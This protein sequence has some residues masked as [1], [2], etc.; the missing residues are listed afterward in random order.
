MK[1]LNKL[2]AAGAFVL[3]SMGCVPEG[4][5]I[6][7]IRPFAGFDFRVSQ[8]ATYA[9][10]IPEY[11][12]DV[13][14]HPDDGGGK[15]GVISD[16]IKIYPL[17]DFALKT[18]LS[19][20]TKSGASLNVSGRFSIPASG[21]PKERD[22]MVNIGEDKKSEGS[23][24][25]YYAVGYG[26]IVIP[27]IDADIYIPIK[28]IDS[29]VNL[30]AI[31]GAGYRKYDLEVQ[32]GWDRFSNFQGRRDYKIGDV[33][34]KSFYTGVRIINSKKDSG[35]FFCDFTVGASLIDIEARKG[36]EVKSNDVS[37]LCGF[38][39]GWRF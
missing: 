32:T 25:T 37:W 19:F 16:G 38:G 20:E 2:L 23:A 4:A 31:V 33:E 11:M 5:K 15:A 10:N 8:P 30:G 27:G 13:P 35:K 21:Y 22:Y 7:N 24:L 12:R 14:I 9:K 1:T 34:E 29:E 26:P 6:D 17:M 28:P 36:V 39:L 3:S 18:G